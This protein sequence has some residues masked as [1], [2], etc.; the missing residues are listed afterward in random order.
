MGEIY[1]DNAATT[2][3]KRAVFDEMK[4]Y[5]RSVCYY[6][7][8]SKHT[9][10]SRAKAA[11]ERARE[12]VASLINAKPEEIYFTSGGTEANNW[13]ISFA[14]GNNVRGAIITDKIEHPSVMEPVMR[15]KCGYHVVDVDGYGFVNIEQIE[16]LLKENGASI[17]SVMTVNNEIGTQQ[18]IKTISTIAHK[19][20]AYMH[21]DAVQAVG[22]VSVDVR[23]TEVDFMSMSSHKIYGPKGVGALFVEE[24]VPMDP[25]IFGG[26]QERGMRSGT[27]NVA[28]IVGFGKACELAEKNMKQNSARLDRL[29]HVFVNMIAERVPDS[30]I[31]GPEQID[32]APHIVSVAFKGVEAETLIMCLNK[33]KIYCSSGSACS[34][35]KL[36]PSRVLRAI[37]VPNEL[38]H[39]TVRFS[40]GDYN[41]E[42]ELATVVNKIAG[43]VEVIR[44]I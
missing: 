18:F 20:G 40:F 34:S 5:L 17:V 13:A 15:S 41:T 43:L 21:T 11:V 23:N 14:D 30:F 38:V 1:L 36:E 31:I 7:P 4:P 12:R 26:G 32:R 29:S 3:I 25:L 2:K 44:S 39:S 8:S 19:N 35:N 9:G 22:H 37:G 24:T 6:N 28:G 16:G 42:K 33:E 27:E 10:G